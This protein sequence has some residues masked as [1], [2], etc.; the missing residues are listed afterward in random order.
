M[1]TQSEET[2]TTKRKGKTVNGYIAFVEGV[3][4]EI[5]ADSLYQASVKARALYTG[6]KKYPSVSVD[7]AEL[8]GE[9]VVSVV[10]A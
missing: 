7:L 2:A 10:T 4:H 6:R 9:Q 8:A 3:R 5:Y 1:A